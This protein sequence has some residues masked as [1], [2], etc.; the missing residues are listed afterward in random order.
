MIEVTVSPTTIRAGVAADLEVRLTNRAQEACT[1]IILTIKL[2]VGIIRL[3]GPGKIEVSELSPS[4]SVILPLR[5]V[6][7]REGRYQLT[8]PHFAYRD[9]RGR[10]HR[11][12]GFT[13]E[14][15]VDPKQDPPPP[16]SAASQK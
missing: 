15:T 16:I 13:A 7:D 3:R 5:V 8:S 12:T 10:P 14:V 9:H 11:G 4:H 2:P 6:A 1:D